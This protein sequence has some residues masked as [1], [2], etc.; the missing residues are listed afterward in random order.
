M[1]QI[2]VRDLDD[3][4][5]DGLK[6]QAKESGRSLQSEAKRILE[7]GVMPSHT[8]AM[9]KI[10]QLQR[11]LKGKKFPDSAALIREDRNR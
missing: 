8:E 4:T 6:R 3:K 2:L 10:L 9:Q 7:E 1:A 11:E 5:V